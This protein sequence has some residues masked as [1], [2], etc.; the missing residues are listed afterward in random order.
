MV[1]E[2]ITCGD[3]SE[4]RRFYLSLVKY[5]FSKTKGDKYLFKTDVRIIEQC[6]EE[7][8]EYEVGNIEIRYCNKINFN[9][10]YFI[11]NKSFVYGF[12]KSLPNKEKENIFNNINS[13]D[14]FSGDE[15]IKEYTNGEKELNPTGKDFLLLFQHINNINYKLEYIYTDFLD[16]SEYPEFINIITLL[17]A[18]KIF[19]V[20]SDCQM[21]NM[22][23]L[24]L[25]YNLSC[26]KYFFFLNLNFKRQI[27]LNDNEK[28]YIKKLFPNIT[29]TDTTNQSFLKLDNSN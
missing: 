13:I 2:K 27:G 4:G 25:L 18:L 23:L 1:N 21:N 6:E 15:E 8:D 11:D 22:Q 7:V 24:Q 5:L 20:N 26:L 14:I 10:Y 3:K 29:I 19:T 12:H 28:D 9:D 16:I 17:H